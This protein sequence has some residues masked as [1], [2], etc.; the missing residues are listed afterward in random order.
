MINQ[1]NTLSIDQSAVDPSPYSSRE[2][3]AYKIADQLY[4]ITPIGKHTIVRHIGKLFLQERKFTVGTRSGAKICVYTRDLDNFLMMKHRGWDDHVLKTCLM[5]LRK[6][7]NFYDVGA[8]AGYISI[9]SSCTMSNSINIV[10]FEPQ[11]DLAR[12]IVA[13]AKINKMENINVLQ[14]VLSDTAG[15][16][17]LYLGK[18]TI[19]ASLESTK[20]GRKKTRG[21]V[22]VTAYTLDGLVKDN[23]LPPPDVIKLDVEGAELAVIKGARRTLSTNHPPI[24]LEC[25]DN[26]KKFGYDTRDLLSE[27]SELGY[28]RF[29]SISQ[30]GLY[31]RITDPAGHHEHDILAVTNEK[32]IGISEFD[33]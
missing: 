12:N 31:K 10:A 25:D 15:R 26:A 18:H 7:S 2:P 19:H 21:S 5:F 9:S 23:G 16:I 17:D 1:I 13:S 30:S 20:T 8:N 32:V 14:C 4:R 24:I 3:L 11:I 22:E 29:Y 33:S 28:E 27:L 6:G